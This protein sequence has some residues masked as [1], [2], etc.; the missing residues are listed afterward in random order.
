MASGYNATVEPT[1]NN[2]AG[3]VSN[4]LYSSFSNSEYASILGQWLVIIVLVVVFLLG[5]VLIYI[6]LHGLGWLK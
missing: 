2:S 1:I 3:Q 6:M 5:I 4:E